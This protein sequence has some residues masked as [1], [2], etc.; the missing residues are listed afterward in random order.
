MMKALRRTA[1]ARLE[2][3]EVATPETGAGDDLLVEMA[4]AAVNP[5]DAQVLRG[6]IGDAERVLTLGA[7]GAGRVD[8][9]PVQVSG[10]GLGVAR[11]GTFA[12]W[13]LAP[14]AA[15]RF[16][17]EDADLALAATVGVAG[18]TAWRAVHQLAEVGAD[19]TVLV[20]GASGGVGTFAAQLARAT[21][22]RVLAHTGSTAKADRLAALGLEPV[23]ADAP[24]ELARVVSGRAVSVVLD[25]LGGD[26][27]ASLLPV[28]A[29]A[30]RVVTYGILAGRT[31]TIDLAT[32]YGKGIRI[33][34]TSGGTTPPEDAD[35]SLEGALAAVLEGA[36]VV[37]HEVLALAEGPVAFD[38]L[39]ERSVSGKLLLG[40]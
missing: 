18:K 8:G 12:P 34:G 39:R 19:D 25:P 27:V 5:F 23:V 10:G 13:V 9:R 29:P 38:R 28:V 16:L 33:L 31:T 37:D 32:L 26:Y 11:D 21:G 22:A 6:E 15:V 17:P 3:R 1:P 4:Y 30:A 20:L 2:V 14:R 35:A 24:D 7:E 36:V 40:M